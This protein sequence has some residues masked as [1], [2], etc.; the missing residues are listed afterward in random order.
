MGRYVVP[1]G[2]TGGWDRFWVYQD[3]LNPV[4]QLDGSGNLEMLFIYAEQAHVPSMVGVP[5]GSGGFVH[6]RVVTDQVGSVRYLVNAADGSVSFA[7][8]YNPFGGLVEPEQ[9]ALAARFPFRFAGGLWDAGTGLIRFGARDY[10]PGTGR[11]TAK[12]RLLFVAAQAG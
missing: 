4:A 9:G 11:W 2:G 5:D 6:H 3:G 7:A 8:R 12:D 10:D 1:A